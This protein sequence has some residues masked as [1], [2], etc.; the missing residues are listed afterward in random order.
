MILQQ[1][2]EIDDNKIQINPKINF[3]VINKF[4][5]SKYNLPCDIFVEE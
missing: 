4:R 3:V 2:K 1:Y 5:I